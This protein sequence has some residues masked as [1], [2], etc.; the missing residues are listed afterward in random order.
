MLDVLNARTCCV[1]LA[2]QWLL[3]AWQLLECLSTHNM[4]IVGQAAAVP[5]WQQVARDLSLNIVLWKTGVQ[6][7]TSNRDINKHK[8]RRPC[9]C[10][11]L[12]PGLGIEM[13]PPNVHIKA[14]GPG[15]FQCMGAIDDGPVHEVGG[16]STL[17]TNPT[18]SAVNTIHPCSL[19]SD[20]Y[21][22]CSAV[23]HA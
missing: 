4:P 10:I 8:Q 12:G 17:H 6:Q 9:G 11:Y 1:R 5:C 23:T 22:H 3:N 19:L 20:T 16:T 14:P 13:G 21:A 18:T 2:G 15:L 7:L